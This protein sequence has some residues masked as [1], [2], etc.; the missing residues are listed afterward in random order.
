MFGFKKKD[1][2]LPG[3]EE[4]LSAISRLE[5]DINENSASVLAERLEVRQ[6]KQENMLEETLEL[7][8]GCGENL[9]ALKETQETIMLQKEQEKQSLLDVIMLYGEYMEQLRQNISKSSG[10]SSQW[11]RQWDIMEISLKRMR[12][13]AGISMIMDD[14]E[15]AD[16]ERVQ[17]VKQEWTSDPEKHN[18]VYE[19][20][21]PGWIYSGKVIQKAKVI[22]YKYG[23]E[24]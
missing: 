20:V 11:D 14:K 21:V 4:I 24:Q 23:E 19:T 7:L 1:S 2:S 16:P 22:V 6:R 8:D 9:E 12:E 10:S 3:N 5:S 15:P 13:K 17:V 18:Y